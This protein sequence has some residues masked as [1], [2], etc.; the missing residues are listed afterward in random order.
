[1]KLPFMRFVP[2]GQMVNE[3]LYQETVAR[4]RDAVRRKRPEMW[5]NQTW[6][7][8]HDNVPT[9]VSL[10]ISSYLAK[11]Q[12]SVVPHPTY[13]PELAPAEFFLFPKLKTTLKE[14]RLQTIEE[15]QENATR[16]LRAITENAFQERNP[17]ME[18][19]LGTV[20]RQ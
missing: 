11:Y 13:S 1:M 6:M 5:E 18:E 16:E 12:I 4:L 9:H 8:L 3:Q 7:L 15:I 20:F 19:K 10:L 17:K 2:G 14:S